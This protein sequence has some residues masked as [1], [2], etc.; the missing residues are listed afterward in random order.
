MCKLAVYIVRVRN[1]CQFYLRVLRKRIRSN[2]CRTLQN[3]KRYYIRR[4]RIITW[5]RYVPSK[6]LLIKLLQFNFAHYMPSRFICRWYPRPAGKVRVISIV[7]GHLQHCL[8]CA[9]ID[10]LA[11]NMGREFDTNVRTNNQLLSPQ[12]MYLPQFIVLPNYPWQSAKTT[13]AV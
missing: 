11:K 7:G 9:C 1:R 12:N 8:N 13:R 5:R 2:R 10:I 6:I 4:F 3:C